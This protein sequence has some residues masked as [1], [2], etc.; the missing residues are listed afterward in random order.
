M[1]KKGDVSDFFVFLCFAFILVILAGVFIWV[2]GEMSSKLKAS[3]FAND[4]FG[5]KNGT[6]I[7]EDTFDNTNVAYSTLYWGTLAI[8]IAMLLS[9]LIGCYM[10]TTKPIFFVPYIFFVA[11]AVIC[12]VA[13][14][15][16]YEKIMETPMLADTYS[17]FI[18]TNFLLLNLPIIISV[19]GV[20][21]A[22]I[23]FGRI[24]SKETQ[25]YGY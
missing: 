25:Y 11:L 8:I 7:V 19:I 18:G 23:M 13:I 3:A 10:V 5:D 14:S 2:G 24:G 16:A 15:N 1:N 17:N 12:S 4:T 21:G 6:Q 22:I 9:I 20:L